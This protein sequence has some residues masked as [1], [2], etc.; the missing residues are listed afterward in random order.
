MNKLSSNL[1]INLMKRELIGSKELLGSN[2]NN[3]LPSNF[4]KSICTQKIILGHIRPIVR[5][6]FDRTGRY[7]ITVITLKLKYKF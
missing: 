7:I 4:L 2:M 3:L 1:L 6:R 5:V